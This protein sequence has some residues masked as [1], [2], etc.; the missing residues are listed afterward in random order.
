MSMRLL[1]GVKLP[2]RHLMPVAVAALIEVPLR[3]SLPL[4]ATSPAAPL[5]DASSR[6]YQR[7]GVAAIAAGSRMTLWPTLRSLAEVAVR[8]PVAALPLRYSSATATV[9]PAPPELTSERSSMPAGVEI[10]ELA[11]TEKKVTRV[12]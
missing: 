12:A 9:T 2:A 3:A 10:E 1:G 5:Q 11:R 8:V 7:L 6:R 4:S